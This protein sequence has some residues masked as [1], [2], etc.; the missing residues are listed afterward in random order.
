VFTGRTAIYYGSEPYFDDGRG[1]LML[2]DRPLAVCDKTAGNL[3]NMGRTDILVTGS[4]WFYDGG[5][6]C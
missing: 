3:Q 6:C 1:H 4:T 2:V 5:G